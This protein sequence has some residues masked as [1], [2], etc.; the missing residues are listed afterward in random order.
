MNELPAGDFDMPPP[1]EEGESAADALDGAQRLDHLN[2]N[3]KGKLWVFE[4]MKDKTFP[5]KPMYV[6]FGTDT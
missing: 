5:E 3:F 1:I 6:E 4:L 2:G